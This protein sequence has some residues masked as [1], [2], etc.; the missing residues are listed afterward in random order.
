MRLAVALA[1]RHGLL[2]LLVQLEGGQSRAPGV[3]EGP[4]LGPLNIDDRYLPVRVARGLAALGP[5][6]RQLPRHRRR[7][8]RHI[9]YEP[10]NAAKV[11]TDYVQ[12]SPI[13]SIAHE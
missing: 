2:R 8:H 9:W 1:A 4:V 11:I 6:L 5:A 10:V 12:E 13:H 7:D 3:A